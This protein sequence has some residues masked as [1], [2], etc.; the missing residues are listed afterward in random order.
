LK[1]KRE[2]IRDEPFGDDAV[3]ATR[4]EETSV[5]DRASYSVQRQVPTEEETAQQVRDAVAAAAAGTVWKHDTLDLRGCHRSGQYIATIVAAG[6][7]KHLACL[8][9]EF[10]MQVTDEHVAALAEWGTLRR[11]NLNAAQ[12]V[13]DR[14]VTALARC[15][16]DLTEIGLYW[17]VRVTDDSV[18][19]L[20][21]SCPGLNKVNLSGCRRLT[22]VS[23][24]ALATLKH[25]EYLDIT[26]CTFSDGGLTAVVLSPGPCA[27]LAHLNLYAVAT[28]TDV[29][30][31]CVGVLQQLTF[32]DLCGSQ[33]LT[34][35][36]LVE[37]AE[38]CELLTYLNLS[39]CNLVTDVGMCAVGRHCTRLELLSVHGNRNVTSAFVA[40]LAANH[41]CP[42]QQP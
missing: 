23:A 38:G 17:N 6:R 13:G 27:N 3:M 42:K 18:A 28:Y 41:R 34:D 2:R 39:W 33:S 25:L 11:V 1:R 35:R 4:G 31:A 9:L 26:R 32:L 12:H 40:I 10:A 7:L 30:F 36:A 16:P 8:N 19:L 20:C 24:K 21:A 29:S 15:S 22:D 5:G 14:A 37:I